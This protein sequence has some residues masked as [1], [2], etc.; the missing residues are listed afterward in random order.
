[1]GEPIQGSFYEQ[2]LQKAKQETEG[3]EKVLRRDNKKKLSRA[4]LNASF[5]LLFLFLF[6]FTASDNNSGNFL[7]FDFKKSH[8]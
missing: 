5:F 4:S 3:I 8:D 6:F 1:M 7:C 2:E